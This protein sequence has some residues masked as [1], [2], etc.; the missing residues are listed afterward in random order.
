MSAHCI[1][2]CEWSD[3]FA[4]DSR[5]HRMRSRA[6]LQ[7]I[8][9]S[10]GGAIPCRCITRGSESPPCSRSKTAH[11]W[12]GQ[13]VARRWA[14]LFKLKV[15]LP[16]LAE[17]RAMQCD[18]SSCNGEE[19][20]FRD[21]FSPYKTCRATVSLVAWH[22]SG[23]GR[24]RK[25]ALVGI[26]PNQLFSLERATRIRKTLGSIPGGAALWFFVWSGCQF[27]YL[28]RRWKRK[29]DSGKKS[30]KGTLHWRSTSSS[31][32]LRKVVG[33]CWQIIRRWHSPG[34]QL[35]LIFTPTVMP[36]A[37]KKKA[38]SFTLRP[39]VHVRFVTWLRVQKVL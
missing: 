37:D 30:S 17:E 25:L 36:L 38:R 2:V 1:W 26:I 34:A 33:C 10:Q 11:A 21:H 39:R 12:S 3:V 13:V 35:F 9:A 16:L 28:C 31:F 32:Y 24:N 7:L 5:Y 29:F 4:I 14:C 15:P 23:T 8:V 22:R 20:S 27:F 19:N 18:W 6:L